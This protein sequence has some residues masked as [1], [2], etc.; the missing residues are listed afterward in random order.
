MSVW[1]A[2]IVCYSWL[3]FLCRGKRRQGGDREADK[4]C[5][6]Q[7][8]GR[9]CY[10]IDKQEENTH[11]CPLKVVV[12]GYVAQPLMA[13]MTFLNVPQQRIASAVI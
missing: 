9:H 6:Q 2:G 4:A 8:S 3:V 10:I 11:Q 1:Y 7:S 5:L 12:T 13:I